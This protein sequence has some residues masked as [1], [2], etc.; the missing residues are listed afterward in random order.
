MTTQMVM[1]LVIACNAGTAPAN[2]CE[3]LR[4][5]ENHCATIECVRTRSVAAS[6]R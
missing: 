4:L 5:A 6:S 1:A 2:Q 3:T